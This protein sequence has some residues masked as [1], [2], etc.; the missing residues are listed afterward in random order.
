MFPRPT[1]QVRRY[2]HVVLCFSPVGDA[3]RE[4]LRKFPSLVTCTTIDWWVAPHNLMKQFHHPVAQL[5]HT[6]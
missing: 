6:D 1:H 5:Q 4:R 3:F 2:L